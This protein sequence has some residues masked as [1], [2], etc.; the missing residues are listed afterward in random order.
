MQIL[1]FVRM[2]VNFLNPFRPDRVISRNVG[3]VPD[4]PHSPHFREPSTLRHAG[5]ALL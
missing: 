2:G 4:L 5:R 1:N 3:N